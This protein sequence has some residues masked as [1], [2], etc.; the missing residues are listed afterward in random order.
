MSGL[1]QQATSQV[2]TEQQDPFDDDADTTKKEE[3]SIKFGYVVGVT[4]QNTLHFSVLGS[5]GGLVELLGLHQYA[6]KKLDT[7]LDMKE[8][9]SIKTLHDQVHVL[10]E[11][12]NSLVGLFSRGMAAHQQQQRDSQIIVPR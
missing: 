12:L 9:L 7:S 6:G 5:Q 2:Q 8:E 3:V 1:E 11:A 4:D 10:T